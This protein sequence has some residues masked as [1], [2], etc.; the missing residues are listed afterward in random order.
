[1]KFPPEI[2]A[3][4]EAAEKI[5]EEQHDHLFFGE[6]SV[7]VVWT[8]G[9]ILGGYCAAIRRMPDGTYTL[10]VAAADVTHEHGDLDYVLACV[11]ER[12]FV[13][14]H[15]ALGKPHVRRFLTL[16]YPPKP[17]KS[18]MLRTVQF[19]GE[20]LDVEITHD[21]GYEPDT[22]AHVIEWQFYGLSPEKHDA[23]QITDE[24]EQSIY[25]QLL[26]ASRE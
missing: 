3:I 18:E 2:V 26:Q 15:L 14:A 7:D 11:P 16:E 6:E 21:G 24:E 20:S 13:S 5:V 17:E 12:F 4:H 25:E 8:T 23:L 10:A 1:M 22:N 9:Y 19:R